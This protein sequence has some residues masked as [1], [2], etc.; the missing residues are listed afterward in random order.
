MIISSPWTQ[1]LTRSEF[2]IYYRMEVTLG[3]YQ[4][5]LLDEISK[6]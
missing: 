5:L 2:H 4:L 3:L 1:S 6:L